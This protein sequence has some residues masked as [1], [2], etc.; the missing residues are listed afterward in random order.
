MNNLTLCDR[1]HNALKINISDKAELNTLL[2]DLA[3]E[4]ETE[5]LVR[6]WDTKKNTEI[7]KETMLA[8]TEL[9][10]MGKGKIPH[11]TID[12]PYDRPRLAPSRR[13]HKICK[14]YL[15]HTRSE[16]AKQYIIAAILYVDSHPEY[17]ELKKGEQI[18]VIRNY[19]KIPNDTA[20]GLVTKL[21]HKRVI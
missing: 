14:G 19:L 6:I 18:K 17:A 7:D 8:I 3:R 5:A 21:K 2:Q 20:R 4:K 10:N 11:G 9:H 12:I 1:V 16:A 13:L 15:L